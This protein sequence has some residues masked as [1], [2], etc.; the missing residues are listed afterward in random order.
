MALNDEY[1]IIVNSFH[2]ALSSPSLL[3]TE[4]LLFSLMLNLLNGL[5]AFLCIFSTLSF[6]FLYC[7]PSS[8]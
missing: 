1:L 7:E 2:V 8:K 3:N 5:L 4:L 6:A